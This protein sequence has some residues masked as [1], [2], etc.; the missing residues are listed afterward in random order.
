MKK[1]LRLIPL[2]LVFQF[3]ACGDDNEKSDRDIKTDMLTATPW[4]NAQ[5]TNIPD[6][7]LSDQYTNFAITFSRNKSGEFD[8]TYFIANGGYA[9]EEVSGK[10]RFSNA[11]DQLILDSGKVMEMELGA[12]NLKLEFTVS[13]PGGRTSGLSGHFTFDLSPL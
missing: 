1:M 2:L 9:F 12:D 10:W 3:A 7:N 8:G 5:V 11:L 13:D 4:G 6:G